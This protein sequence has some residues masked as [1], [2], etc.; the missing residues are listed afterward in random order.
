MWHNAPMA[1]NKLVSN[2][3]QALSKQRDEI[4]PTFYNSRQSAL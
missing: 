1:L 4:G 3:R 2:F